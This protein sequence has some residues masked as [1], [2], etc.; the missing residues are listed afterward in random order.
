MPVQA[1]KLFSRKDASLS[2][3]IGLKSGKELSTM[4]T[5]T[6]PSFCMLSVTFMVCIIYV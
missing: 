4:K 6:N 2:S 1:A 5:K 3:G